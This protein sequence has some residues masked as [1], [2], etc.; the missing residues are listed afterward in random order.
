MDTYGKL[1]NPQ[2]VVFE[3]LRIYQIDV[4]VHYISSD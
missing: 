3:R 2:T 4:V 1:I